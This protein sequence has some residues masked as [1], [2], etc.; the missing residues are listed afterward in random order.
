MGYGNS[1]KQQCFVM[2]CCGDTMHCPPWNLQ[3]ALHLD[4]VDDIDSLDELKPMIS[5][6]DKLLEQ[7]ALESGPQKVN[8][9]KEHW[10]LSVFLFFCWE[11]MLE[12]WIRIVGTTFGVGSWPQY[13]H[14]VNLTDVTSTW[15]FFF[16]DSC[17]E[18]TKRKLQP[19]GCYTKPGPSGKEHER[20]WR[21][22]CTWKKLGP[23]AV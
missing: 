8:P 15:C 11:W 12:S 10:N 3:M 6:S 7:S 1:I 9:K 17:V 21:L 2:V 19:E 5:P 22:R 16:H 20:P 13:I 4:D 14:A 23:D 18:V